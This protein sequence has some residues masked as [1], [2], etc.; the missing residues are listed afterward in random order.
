MSTVSPF[1]EVSASR[2]FIWKAK[3]AQARAKK[4]Q[5]M[6]KIFFMM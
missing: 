2:F 6:A 5:K 3:K 1:L 4:T